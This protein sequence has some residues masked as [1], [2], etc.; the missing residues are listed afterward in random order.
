M[1]SDELSRLVDMLIVHF[2]SI[3]AAARIKPLQAESTKSIIPLAE[4]YAEMKVNFKTGQELE[5]I[6]SST[7]L[8]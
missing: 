3:L 2:L 7:W 6:T 4:A 8:V 1:Q 5:V